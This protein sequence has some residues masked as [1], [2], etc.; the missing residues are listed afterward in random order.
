VIS[1]VRLTYAGATKFD[2]WFAAVARPDV[3]RTEVK[4]ELSAW[5][6]VFVTHKLPWVFV[7]D[8]ARS[9]S[10]NDERLPLRNGDL[11][12]EYEEPLD[13]LE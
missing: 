3:E 10:G 2:R 11:S 12:I 13:P 6:V 7:L 9:I 1:D 8:A 5:A 4:R